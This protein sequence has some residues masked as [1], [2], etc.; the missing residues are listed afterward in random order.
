M[1][2]IRTYSVNFKYCK[3]AVLASLLFTLAVPSFANLKKSENLEV[4]AKEKDD[5]EKNITNVKVMFNPVA[6]QISI[7]F[8]LT[9]QSTVSIK[10]MDALGNEVMNL[11]NSNLESGTQNHSFDTNEKVTPGFYFV[12]VTSGSETIIKRLAIR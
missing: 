9:K 1:K 3:I 7:S 2:I 6:E 10:L 8:K 11:L 12:R 5:S 4:L